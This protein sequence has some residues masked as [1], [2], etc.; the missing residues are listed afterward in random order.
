MNGVFDGV[1]LDDG[2]LGRQAG[3]RAGRGGL[4]EVPDPDVD[5]GRDLVELVG[6]RE[7]A[8][9]ELLREGRPSGRTGSSTT[10]TSSSAP[11]PTA[12]G[13]WGGSAAS[14]RARRGSSRIRRSCRWC[15]P[16]FWRRWNPTSCRPRATTGSLVDIDYCNNASA[17]YQLEPIDD[18]VIREWGADGSLTPFTSDDGRSRRSRVREGASARS[19]W[20]VPC[21]FSARTHPRVLICFRSIRFVKEPA[22]SPPTTRGIGITGAR[23][24]RPLAH[25][26]CRQ[27]ACQAPCSWSL[28]P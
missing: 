27:C 14:T 17:I 5:V 22:G 28:L 13:R 23:R 3:A 10:T 1:S 6:R 25:Q 20:R 19:D 4:G 26:A 16:G 7:L 12:R 24:V 9:Q 2:G 21:T 15:S 8:R 11:S 18:I